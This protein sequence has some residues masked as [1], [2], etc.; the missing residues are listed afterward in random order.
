MRLR[1]I[2]R[3]VVVLG[4]VSLLTDMASEM[5]YPVMPLFLVGTLR[6]SPALLGLIDG[7]AEG[8]SSVLR[9][10][11]GALSDR[12]RR[13]KPFVVA[14]YSISALSKPVM[15]LA[16]TVGGWPLFLLGRCTDRLGK[17][18]RTSSR[19]ALIAD[20]TEPAYRG[21]AF[22]LHRAMDTTGAILGPLV[23]LVIVLVRP[24]V[25]LQW[26]FFVALL[27]GVLSSLLAQLAI[28]EI[29]HEAHAGAKPP[30]IFL[31]YPKALWQLV[32]AAAIFSLGNSSDAFLILRSN[33]LGLSFAQV[34]LAFAVYNAV[35]AL[36]AIPL[37]RLSDRVG[38]KPMVVTGW[39]VYAGVYLGFSVA[40]SGW[41]PWGLLGAYGLYQALS[42]GVTKALIADVVPREQRAG[43][44]GL[45]Y[46]VSGIGQLFASVLAGWLWKVRILQGR[47]MVAFL[48]GAVFA[49]V[50]APLVATVRVKKA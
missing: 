46:T 49:A 36:G 30:A 11:A 12:F 4:W 26:L 25:P 10:L 21:T 37:G 19:D 45:F 41:A 17:S 8:G 3:N 7:V 39:L 18:I 29:R 5:L 9:W 16:A 43:A 15:G 23:A 24:D 1:G 27:P 34:I 6:A 38:R 44:I 50:A 31:R 2:T 48:I 35:Y 13:R 22:G 42:E 14:G 28:R 32:G 20:S 40:R 47:M 33:E